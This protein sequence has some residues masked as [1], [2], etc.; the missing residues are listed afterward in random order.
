M[1]IYKLKYNTR[2]E[3]E[4]DLQGRDLVAVVYLQPDDPEEVW[5]F[6][7]VDVM[8]ETEQTFN[9]ELKD[10]ETPKHKFL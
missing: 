1:I 9:G 4:Q 7:L 3:A 5:N 2:A 8:S 6:C 10:P